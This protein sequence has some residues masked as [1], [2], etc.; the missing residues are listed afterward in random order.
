MK[1]LIAMVVLAFGLAA[2]AAEQSLTLKVEGWHSKGDGYK[3]EQAVRQVKGVR[4]ATADAA[5]KQLTV[6]YDDATTSV[7]AIQK[8]ITEAGYLSHR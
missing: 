5:A 1:R 2:A 7:A 8:A 4:N 6:V 3:T